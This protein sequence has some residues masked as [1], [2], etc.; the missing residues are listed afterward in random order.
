[1]KNPSKIDKPKL[2]N[3]A[4]NTNGYHKFRRKMRKKMWGK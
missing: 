2:I 1:M 4:V 3:P